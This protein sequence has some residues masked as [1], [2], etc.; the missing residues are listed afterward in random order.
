MPNLKECPKCGKMVDTRGYSGHVANCK[1]T[2]E[3]KDPK[4][5]DQKDSVKKCLKCGSENLIRIDEYVKSS[6]KEYDMDKIY[7]L[8]VTHVCNDCSEVLK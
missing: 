2:K 7:A 5:I 4:Q 1:G 6:G 8:G 3:I